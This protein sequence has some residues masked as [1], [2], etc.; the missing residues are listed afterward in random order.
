MGVRT[1]F[2]RETEPSLPERYFNSARKTAM[3]SYKIALP[4]SPHPIIISKKCK[5][6]ISGTSPR[7]TEGIFRFFPFN[8]YVK[9]FSFHF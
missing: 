9:C 5:L 6:Q 1:I 4:D 3:L 7:Q 2:S 8:K